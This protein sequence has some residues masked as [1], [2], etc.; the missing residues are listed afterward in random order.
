MTPR[1]FLQSAT[2]LILGWKLDKELERLRA[3]VAELRAEVAIYRSG[4]NH[5]K[6]L[7]KQIFERVPNISVQG[8]NAKREVIY[9]N[10]ASELLYGFSANEAIGLRLE[11]LIIPD[12][13]RATV[14]EMVQRWVDD[15]IAI[16]PS[17][18]VLVNKWKSEV[19]V[20]S[21]HFRLDNSDQEFEMFCFDIDIQKTKELEKYLQDHNKQL[22]HLA[23]YDSLTNLPNRAHFLES[24]NGAIQRTS[25]TNKTLAVFFIDLDNFKT[26]NDTLGHEA[27][28]NVLRFAAEC[29]RTSVRRNDFVARLAGD[30]FTVIVE[31]LPC[32]SEAEKIAKRI[33]NSILKSLGNPVHL[34][35]CQFSITPS[36]GVAMC[37]DASSNAD[38][39]V[40]LADQAMYQAK[41]SG[42]NSVAF[43]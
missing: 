36:I 22:Y 2:D 16:P 5:Q 18:L 17:E 15:D 19:H 3:E 29:L 31:D 20:Y 7:F 6:T 28:D 12:S 39:L 25:R 41:R 37:S 11:D 13:M 23:N 9:W 43:I 34:G 14:I 38:A 10:R 27:G 33:A 26:V 21:H 1:D 8:Y 4:A 24:L 32:S 35:H 42:K 30:E 40:S